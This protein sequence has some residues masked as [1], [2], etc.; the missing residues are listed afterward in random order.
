MYAYIIV[1]QMQVHI[2]YHIA[3]SFVVE[4]ISFCSDEAFPGF[5]VHVN[6]T[7]L[8]EV[9]KKRLLYIVILSKAM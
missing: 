9:N 8:M 7:K 6:W 5:M 2:I 3:S 4:P 1:S